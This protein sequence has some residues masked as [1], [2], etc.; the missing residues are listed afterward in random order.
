MAK[1]RPSSTGGTDLGGAGQAVVELCDATPHGMVFWTRQRFEIGAELQV[2]LR[3]EAL[4]ESL[5]CHMPGVGDWINLRG[6]VV[7]CLAERRSNGNF[8]FRVSLLLASSPR[9]NRRL[10]VPLTPT[11]DVF[12]QDCGRLNRQRVGKN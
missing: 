11:D 4:P 9:L 7:Q 1:A 8:G 12:L 5:R 10:P 6:Y 2:R 3:S